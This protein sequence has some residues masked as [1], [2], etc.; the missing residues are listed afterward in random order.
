MSQSGTSASPT[1]AL[2]INAGG[3]SRRMGYPK[4]LL[5]VPPTG[6]P[7][8]SA[9]IARLAALAPEA[10]HIIANDPDLRTQLEAAQRHQQDDISAPPPD[11]QPVPSSAAADQLRWLSDRYP[12]VGPL[13]GIATGLDAIDSWGIFVACDMPLLNARLFAYLWTLAIEQD[14]AGTERWD[15]VVPM[16]NGFAEPL[17]ALYH[18]RCLD[19]VVNSIARGERRATSFLSA[20]RV[21]YVQEEELLPYDEALHS[22]LNANTREEWERIC[23]LMTNKKECD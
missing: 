2:I 16:V 23:H 12:K 20:V 14:N 22:F 6:M 15:A 13:G 3:E 11:G 9:I 18:R 4:A 19:A 7:L 17:H 5:P 8:L 10:I 1:Y 21:R